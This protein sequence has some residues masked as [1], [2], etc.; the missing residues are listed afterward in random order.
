M[1]YQEEERKIEMQHDYVMCLDSDTSRWAKIIPW[2]WVSS[3]I[4]LRL[5]CTNTLMLEQCLGHIL[6]PKKRYPNQVAI[7]CIY[8]SSWSQYQLIPHAHIVLFKKLPHT[9]KSVLFVFMCVALFSRML[10]IPSNLLLRE[11]FTFSYIWMI[12]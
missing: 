7:L 1:W 10:S 9:K 5:L 8:S 3:P 12:S 2:T 6:H 4:N 11:D